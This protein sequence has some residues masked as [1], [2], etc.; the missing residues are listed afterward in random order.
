MVRTLLVVVLTLGLAGTAAASQSVG[1]IDLPRETAARDGSRL[2]LNGAGIR[3]RFFI[4]VYVG[5]LYLATPSGDADAIIAADRPARM[6]MHFRYGEIE[7][8]R[9]NEAWRDGFADN[10]DDAVL[11]AIRDRLETFLELTPAAVDED[12]VL[13][14]E[15]LPGEGT[16]VTTNGEVV[17]LIDGRDFFE[18]LLRVWIG[19]NPPDRRLRSGVLGG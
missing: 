10:N 4:R 11:G 16:Q 5:A 15:Y 17:G 8:D 7:R 19:P 12:D 9:L 18:A 6:E 1:G 13:T 14:Y 2:V 3:S